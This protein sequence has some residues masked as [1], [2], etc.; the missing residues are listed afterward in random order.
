M[1]CF[2]CKYVCVDKA[3]SGL[4]DMY[5]HGPYMYMYR[6]MTFISKL[7]Y[8]ETFLVMSNLVV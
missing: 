6:P 5:E 8:T 4:E 7:V 3:I 2:E 1:A